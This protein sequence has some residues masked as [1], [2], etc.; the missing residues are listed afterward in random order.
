MVWR[1]PSNYSTRLLIQW[2]N[3]INII[4][5]T[6][7]TLFSFVSTRKYSAYFS[8]H[9]VMASFHEDFETCN[10][11]LA[12]SLRSYFNIFM[13]IDSAHPRHPAER[14]GA[15]IQVLFLGL[16]RLYCTWEE[17]TASIGAA[18]FKGPPFF[19]FLV[20]SSC[21]EIA[22]QSNLHGVSRDVTVCVLRL[23]SV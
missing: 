11:V 19:S 22:D 23:I 14:N 20:V 2:R 4:I 17:I 12:I 6:C 8:P 9:S 16:A 7:R 15:V 1:M 10:I 21:R 18:L 5:I 13:S 3:C